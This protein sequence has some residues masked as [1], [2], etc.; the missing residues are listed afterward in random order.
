MSFACVQEQLIPENH[1]LFEI[2]LSLQLMR[3]IAESDHCVFDLMCLW[4]V[5][6]D[7]SPEESSLKVAV[8]EVAE[9]SLLQLHVQDAKWTRRGIR[10]CLQVCC[11]QKLS[12]RFRE[13]CTSIHASSSPRE[14]LGI[15]SSSHIKHHRVCLAAIWQQAYRNHSRESRAGRFSSGIC[16]GHQRKVLSWCRSMQTICLKR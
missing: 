1:A 2:V 3:A 5:G 10:A 9:G 16:A 6:V 15:L 8:S 11:M 13:P 12:H 4:Q 14:T 7:V